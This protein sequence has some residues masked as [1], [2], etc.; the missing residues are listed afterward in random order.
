V[1]LKVFEFTLELQTELR[2]TNSSCQNY[3]PRAIEWV[4][5]EVEKVIFKFWIFSFGTWFR[6]SQKS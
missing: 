1:I 6:G 5:V 4:V 2:K 3:S